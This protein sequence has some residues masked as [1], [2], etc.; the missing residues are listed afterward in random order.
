MASQEMILVPA[1]EHHALHRECEESQREAHRVALT[2]R[3]A[4]LRIADLEDMVEMQDQL[5]CINAAAKLYLEKENA[6]LK[7]ARDEAEAE[8][9]RLR[10]RLGELE[11]L[12]E[13]GVCM[14]PPCGHHLCEACV[15]KLP[16]ERCRRKSYRGQMLPVTV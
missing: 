12:P 6:Q 2:N 5:L 1:E 8:A 16:K 14:R 11:A 13:C 10:A 15:A 7:R 9:A 3:K 4:A